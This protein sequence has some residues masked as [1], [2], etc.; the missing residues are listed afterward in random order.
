LKLRLAGAEAAVTSLSAASVAEQAAQLTEAE[1]SVLDRAGL[2]ETKSTEPGALERS[3]I[4]LELLLRDSLTLGQ[5]AKLLQVGTSRLRQR[6]G[7]K[8]STLYGFKEGRGWRIP[9]FQLAGKGKLVR[10]IEKVFPHI[11][12]EAHLLS[13]ATWFSAQHPDLVVGDDEKPV[14]PLEWLSAGLS[15]ELVAQLAEDI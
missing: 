1:A 7:S 6:L 8:P 2:L 4:E 5:A 15:P 14:S 3:R 13:V 10:G 11:R 12:A 9:R